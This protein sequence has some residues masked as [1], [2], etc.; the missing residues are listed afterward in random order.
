M[1][2]NLILASAFSI[3]TF[4][5]SYAQQA[6][7]PCNAGF[8]PGNCVENS[9]TVSN[10]DDNSGVINPTDENGVGCN[11]IGSDLTAGTIGSSSGAQDKDIWFQT[12]VDANGEVSVYA[13]GSDPVLGIY[14]SPTNNCN[15]LV[16]ESCD[17]DGG[18]SLDA[19]AT[20]SGLTPGETVWIRVW[21]YNGGTGTY[22]IAASGGTPP[23]NDDC[24]LAEPL[25]DGVSESGT[26]YCATA[27]IGDYNDCELN[28]ENNVWYTFTTTSDGD[29]TV[30][31]DAVDCFGSGAGVDVSVF[32]GTCATSFASYGCTAIS[33]GGSGS[34]PTFTGPAGTYYVM[35]DGDNS[36]G[37]TALCDFDIVYDF[38][39]CNADA[40]TNITAPVINA[41]AGVDVNVETL[42]PVNTS[43][44]SD[45]CIGW[46]FWVKDDPLG[47]FAG[48]TNIGD[49]PTGNNPAGAGGDPNY[50]GVWTSVDEPLANGPVAVL[51]NE[52]NGVTY[53][54]APVTLSNCQTGEI[55]T[56]CFDIG[57]VTEVYFNPE[58]TY[59]QLIECDAAGPPPTTQVTFVI[60]GGLPSVDGSNFT[61]T[62]NAGNSAGALLNGSAVSATIGEGGTLVVT[63]ITDGESVDI[64]ITDGAG[65]TRVITI[66][67]IDATAYCPPGCA[68]DAGITTTNQNG[69]G[70]TSAN[71]GTSGGPFTLCWGDDYTTVAS[72]FTL[73]D[74]NTGGGSPR[75]I[76]VIYTCPPSNPDPFSDPCFSGVAYTGSSWA[77]VNDGALITLLTDPTPGGFGLTLTDNQ[78]WFVATT[79][80]WVSNAPGGG[81]DIDADGDGCFDT[82]VPNN[83]QYLNE[84]TFSVVDNCDGPEFTINGGSPEFYPTNSYIITETGGGDLV[85]NIGVGDGD[86]F[87]L[88]GIEDGQTYNID[89]MDPNGCMLNITGTYNYTAPNPSVNNLATEFCLGD[90]VDNFTATPTPGGITSGTIVGSNVTDNG[91][92]TGS[93]NPLAVGTHDIIY[94]F[95]N[96][97][98]CVYSDTLAVTVHQ[99]PALG[100]IT[101]P[102]ICFG[103]TITLSSY[104]PGEA[105]GVAGIGTW[106]NGTDN[107]GGLAPGG[108]FTPSN[109][110][111][112]YYEYVTTAGSCSEG[113]VLTIE[114]LPALT[115]TVSNTICFE[116]AGIVVNGTTYDASNPTGTE[117]I[118]NVGPNNCDSTVTINLNVLPVKTGTVSN[119]IC[120]EDA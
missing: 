99:V 29:I 113:Q 106:Y 34:V 65:C 32:Y 48:M 5:V 66:S 9:V 19:L 21:D 68:A 15:N 87:G 43:L 104:V 102:S 107:T 2:K 61:V 35:V 112:Y 119:T 54:V 44:G 36:G 41:C 100:S 57:T 31:I 18:T 47:V 11:S 16:L 53:Y 59:T 42:L 103:E 10:S 114:V 28:T 58:I 7:D 26:T 69:D 33:A 55:T 39:G 52:A 51:P 115:G 71:N 25:A 77:D 6:S 109:G 111:E 37:A 120:F 40:G 96:G 92:G 3:V 75:E 17:D 116:D 1:T 76:L 27:E 20:A 93:F 8:L 46:G 70:V 90:A 73:P 83:I 85:N 86:S 94:N 101:N 56:S 80:D 82:G 45:P 105:N 97:E 22:T 14:S 4:A 89:V 118:T 79:V 74:D 108:A 72:G 64:T 62:P 88:E 50:A 98:G 23:A 38:V 110:A 95:D 30:S 117:V 12:T 24:V 60:S 78:I 84:I 13:A 63:G 67:N 91:N 81:W 49:L